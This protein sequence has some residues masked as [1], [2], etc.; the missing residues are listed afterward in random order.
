[1]RVLYLAFLLGLPW[2][3]FAPLQEPGQ[4]REDARAALEKT[5]AAEGIR[6]D[7][8][9]GVVSLPATVLMREELLE[10][11]LVG[12][13]GAAHESLF[14]TR[15]RPSLLKAALLLTGVEQGLNARWV[16]QPGASESDDLAGRELVPPS[17]DGFYLYAGWRE[18]GE[19]YFFR[20]E[21]LVANLQ[22]GRTMR[23]HRWVFLGSRFAALRE[24]E[25]EVFLADVEGNLVNI[26]F[27]FQGNTLLTA[28]IEE[29]LE[30]TIWVA[31]AWLVPPAEQPVRLFFARE[32]VSEPAPEWIDDLPEVVAVPEEPEP[33]PD[34]AGEER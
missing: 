3:A 17:G 19:T 15:V 31:N 16:K 6:L 5:L 22:T 29:C 34:A 24:G 4:A 8:E 23:R 13:G 32:L 1:M 11:L 21:D 28:A 33:D 25:P 14:A 26:S 20:V 30:Q 18:G 12:P 7:L 2:S 9:R 27:F 10:Y